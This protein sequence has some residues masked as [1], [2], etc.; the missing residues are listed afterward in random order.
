VRAYP[1]PAINE[2]YFKK[3]ISRVA[4]LATA[5]AIPETSRCNS[6]PCR[7]ARHR[8]KA[9]TNPGKQATGTKSN[10]FTI[11]TPGS[12]DSVKLAR[13]RAP[14]FQILDSSTARRNC[15]PSTSN[16]VA[17]H[18]DARTATQK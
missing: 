6:V 17:H 5:S 10:S 4:K 8:K 15:K 3:D 9:P 14:V 2:I 7:R 16:A 18:G 12:V 1:M 13:V 11:Q